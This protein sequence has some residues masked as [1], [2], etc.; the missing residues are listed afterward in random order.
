MMSDKLPSTDKEYL[1]SLT[2]LIDL[3]LISLNTKIDT[4]TE[5]LKE[6]I[7]EVKSSLHKSDQ[8]FDRRLDKVVDKLEVV[9]R[10]AINKI[11]EVK[12]THTNHLVNFAKMEA[13]S[14]LTGKTWNGFLGALGGIISS[15]LVVI[16]VKLI[17]F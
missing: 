2:K 16:L 1:Q 5:D 14:K 11:D 6:K 15:V 7:S 3:H 12:D 17:G 13:E 8:I 9:H 4:T 10:D